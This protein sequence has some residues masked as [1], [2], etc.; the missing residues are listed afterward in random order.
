MTVM[1][2]DDLEDAAETLALLVQMHGHRATVA[3]TGEE[4]LELAAK[5]PPDVVLL[6][7]ALPGLDGWEVAR[8]LRGRS[9]GKRPLL[10]A[11]TGRGEEADRH[12]SAEA[13]IG[14]HLLK[15]VDPEELMGVLARFARVLGSADSTAGVHD[16]V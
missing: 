4:A 11:V 8:R 7:L 12:R 9:A 13:G 15:P 14:L 1:V 16:R 2:V 10:I 6:D 3:R 5:A